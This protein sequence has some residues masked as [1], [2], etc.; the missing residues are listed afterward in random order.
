MSVN[1]LYLTQVLSKVM[2]LLLLYLQETLELS[3]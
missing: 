3:L 2:H 1:L